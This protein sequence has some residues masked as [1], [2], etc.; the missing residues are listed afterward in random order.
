MRC[1]E[2]FESLT[3]L[4]PGPGLSAALGVIELAEVPND[5]MLDVVR[6][7]YRQLCHEQARMAAALSELGRCAGFP[8]AG[9]VRRLP[10]P[11]RYASE[12]SRAA[13]RWTRRAAEDEHEL[14][15]KVVTRWPA[16]FD[17]WLAGVIDRPR[18]R[19]FD[20]YLTGLTDGQAA[21]I[22]QVA[23]PRATD[24]T[25]GQLRVLLRRMVIAVDPDAANRW[26][27]KAVA[28]RN[29]VAYAAAD[30][31]VTM[32]ANGLSADEAEAA[33]VRLQ[34][35]ASRA[36]R[37]GHR[38]VIGQIRC[39]L[40]LGMLDGRFH[41]LT[42]E[43]VIAALIADHQ[44]AEARDS[45]DSDEAETGTD[46]CR[47]RAS[48]AE[49]GAGP[50]TGR[51]YC[52]GS[53]AESTSDCGVSSVPGADAGPGEHGSG[54][55]GTDP[56]PGSAPK[57]DPRSEPAPDQR[58]GIEIRVGLATLLGLDEHPAE[59]PGLGL[60]L[61][62]GARRRVELQGRA[63]WRFALTDADGRLVFD[64][65]TRRRPRHILRAGPPGGIVEL[66]IPL[67]L[68]GELLP[69]G[70]RPADENWTGLI[71][72]IA[73]Q[74]SLTDDRRV[75]LDSYP[76]ARLPRAA[77]RRHTEIRD[78]TCIF[79][80]CR[81]RAHAADQDHSRDHQHGGPTT[82]ANLGPLCPHDHRVKHRGGWRVQQPEPGT[83]V[84]RSPLGGE[85]LSSGEPV[86]PL[87]PGRSGESRRGPTGSGR[88]TLRGPDSSPPS[89]GDRLGGSGTPNTASR[90]SRGV[91]S[92]LS[93]R[94]RSCSERGAATARGL[95][96]RER[97]ISSSGARARPWS[98]GP[99]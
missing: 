85:Y 97:S 95:R 83:F 65:I 84:W 20:R 2:A 33:C 32:S 7:Q 93:I 45:A 68:L 40:F 72:D 69:G 57:G 52:P 13:L 48:S 34:N 41:N 8:E 17:A 15:D 66:H 30:G 38:G 78:G 75:A 39:D 22:C 51:R 6:A 50:S 19:V 99:R 53:G 28:E 92:V 62:P 3:E 61:A 91:A 21:R 11:E 90:R 12:E 82:P 18:V 59:I 89:V 81:R 36:K 64:G 67:T 79:V 98:M 43:Q 76:A 86:L 60:L 96:S 42:S 26:Y 49:P 88:R 25:T 27:R 56:G 73:A 10:E 58:V 71:A 70:A 31:T 47:A 23:V 80:G 29:V 63:E 14:A 24:M 9:E 46:Q 77:L 5:T 87:M 55:P 54:E 35:L 1:A 44:S 37:A 16:V 94:S 4:R 74:H